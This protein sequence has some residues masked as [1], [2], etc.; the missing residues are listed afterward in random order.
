MQASAPVNKRFTSGGY[1]ST[2]LSFKI[3]KV[4]I[5][6]AWF[7]QLGEPSACAFYM[8]AGGRQPLR[9]TQHN[10]PVSSMGIGEILE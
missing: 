3:L 6:F 2:M 8:V 5:L 1:D 10:L 7:R 4:W 9:L